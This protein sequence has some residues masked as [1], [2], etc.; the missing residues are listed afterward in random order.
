MKFSNREK[1]YFYKKYLTTDN[2]KGF[3]FCFIAIFIIIDAIVKQ[4]F[5]IESLAD[6]KLLFSII[7]LL[8]SDWIAKTISLYFQNKYE[9]YAKETNDYNYLVKKYSLSKLITYDLNDYNIKLPYELICEVNS[10]DEIIIDDIPDKFYELPKQVANS[11][12]CILSVHKGSVVYNNINIRL[13]NIDKTDNKIVLSTSRTYYFD[14]LLTNRAC[15]LSLDNGKSIREIF[16]PGPYI[17]PF[18]S[19]KMSNHIGF[20]G[21]IKTSDNYIP[22]V[23]RSRDVSVAKG[24]LAS[25]VS[26]SLKSKYAINKSTYRFDFDGLVNAIKMEIFDEL[27]VNLDRIDAKTLIDSIKYFYRDLIECGKPQFF[28]YIDIPYTKDYINECFCADNVDSFDKEQKMKKDGDELVFFKPSELFNT[29]LIKESG[30]DDKINSYRKMKIAN[31]VF[32]ATPG[33]LMSIK[34]LKSIIDG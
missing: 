1:Y 7:I 33:M 25:S 9:D 11:S 22:L 10:G 29:E 16:E 18:S 32:E 12:D 14:S 26:A 28:V 2:I 30:D 8:I 27:N 20:N 6:M 15:D 17:R 13:D 3:I 34:F 31:V 5:D 21:L 24:V 23:M 4:K 19:S